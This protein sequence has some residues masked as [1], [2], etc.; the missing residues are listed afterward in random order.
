MRYVTR[1]AAVASCMQLIKTL[2]LKLIETLYQLFSTGPQSTYFNS[3][4]SI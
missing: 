2:N 1:L 4:E 3:F